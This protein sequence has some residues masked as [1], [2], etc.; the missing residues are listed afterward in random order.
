MIE[1]AR[2]D[3]EKKSEIPA[4]QSY[5]SRRA[6]AYRP[7]DGTLEHIPE[8]IGE[9]FPNAGS[10]EP[11]REFY[12]NRLLT[13]SDEIMDAARRIISIN[14]DNMV[15]IDGQV[16]RQAAETNRRVAALVISGVLLSLIFVGIIGP[17]IVRPI[18]RLTRSVREI[19]QG[20][21][22]LFVKVRSGMKSDNW[23]PH[24]MR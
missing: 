17:A 22:D 21:L 19:Q 7:A 10:E 6:G 9:L 1:A 14:L 11:R 13:R 23:P 4:G 5:A 8:R 24:S 3:F 18:S 2:V 12:R 16:R 15:S 20:N